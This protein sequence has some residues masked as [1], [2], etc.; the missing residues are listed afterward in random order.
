VSR[1]LV[2]FDIVHHFW[3]LL[4]YL[5]NTHKKRMLGIWIEDW[6]L[7]IEKVNKNIRIRI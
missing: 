4:K 3:L 5:T 2:V 6:Q 7:K 1:N